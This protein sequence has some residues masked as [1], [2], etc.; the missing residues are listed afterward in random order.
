MEDIL[1]ELVGEIMDEFDEEEPDIQKI[2][3]WVYLIDSRAWVER[4]NEDL[5]ISLPTSESY[6][7]IG[8]LIIDQLGHIP[9]KGEVV[10]I[11]ESGIRLMVMKMDDRRIEN[12][13]LIFPM[14]K[15]IHANR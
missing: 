14:D 9:D 3:D 10:T 1:E 11:S 15:D 2:N 5:K 4:V 13:K 8:G 7:T 6:E 12:I